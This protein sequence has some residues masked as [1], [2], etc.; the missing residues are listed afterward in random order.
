MVSDLTSGSSDSVLFV[1]KRSCKNTQGH[2]HVF[3]TKD[4]EA[5]ICGMENKEAHLNMRV[6]YRKFDADDDGDVSSVI[7]VG[8]LCRS[9]R[10]Y[11]TG[12]L[13]D[14]DLPKPSLGPN[15]YG[16]GENILDKYERKAAEVKT[17]NL[18]K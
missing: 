11:L 4:A 2:W 15:K 6:G 8:R 10:E 1:A 5:S 7:G 9:C 18:V 13:S 3:Q 16:T 12:S 14:Q 17:E